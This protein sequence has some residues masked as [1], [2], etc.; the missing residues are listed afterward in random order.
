MG[1]R[2]NGGSADR[3]AANNPAAADESAEKTDFAGQRCGGTH[4]SPHVAEALSEIELELK[5]LEA[6]ETYPP[7][8][9]Q[10]MHRAFVLFGL[11]HKLEKEL[12]R[13]IQEAEVLGLLSTF[14]N[15]DNL[16]A[17]DEDVELGGLDDD[18]ELPSSIVTH[19]EE[20]DDAP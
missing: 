15:L 14:Y 4:N 11:R 10:G 20:G 7:H 1:D 17:D 2:S 5:L 9:L 16:K 8:K 6:L 3:D 18:F 12:K 13:P 19:A